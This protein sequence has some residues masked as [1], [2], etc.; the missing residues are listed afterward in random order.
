MASAVQSLRFTR[1]AASGTEDREIDF[2]RSPFPVK[3]TASLPKMPSWRVRRSCS[4]SRFQCRRDSEVHGPRGIGRRLPPGRPY[5]NRSRL[6]KKEVHASA[7]R[8][9]CG[10]TELNVGDVF[11]INGFWLPTAAGM[12]RK[13]A[14][15]DRHVWVGRAESDVLR[16]RYRL[17]DLPVRIKAH[18]NRAEFSIKGGKSLLPVVVTGLTDWKHPR[19]WRKEKDRWRLLLALRD[20]TMMATRCSRKKRAGSGPCSLSAPSK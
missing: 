15:G 9:R 4:Q 3:G 6:D 11:E 10:E 7:A 1:F 18:E 20:T 17:S 19:I 14:R 2:S 13:R 16:T 8:S 12:M 5:R